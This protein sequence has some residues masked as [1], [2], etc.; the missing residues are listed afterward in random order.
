MIK[1]EDGGGRDTGGEEDGEEQEQ[2]CHVT[3][4]LIETKGSVEV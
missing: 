3:T 2:A 1:D 4:S